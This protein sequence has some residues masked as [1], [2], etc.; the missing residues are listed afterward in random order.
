MQNR[1]WYKRLLAKK[2]SDF[3]EKMNERKPENMCKILAMAGIKPEKNKLA[4]DFAIEASE[5]MQAHADKDGFGFA[6]MTKDGALFGER[7]LHQ[8]DVFQNRYEPS[9][10]EKKALADFKGALVRPVAYNMFGAK[11]DYDNAAAIIMHARFATC[12]KA[13]YN[14]HP[15]VRDGVALIHNGV[16]NN[17]QELDIL[18]S[19]CDSESILNAYV[20][21]GVDEIPGN[22]DTVA[23]MLR[24]S[25]AVAT[26]GLT[27]TAS[28][29]YM[30]IFKNAATSLCVAKIKELDAWV[31]ATTAEIINKTAN[32]LKMTI[33]AS[34]WIMPGYLIRTN[35]L[36]GEI[37]LVEQFDTEYH[38]PSKGS[39][40]TGTGTGTGTNYTAGTG[41]SR[42]GRMDDV[43]SDDAPFTEADLDK[44]WERLEKSQEP[45]EK[46]PFYV[47]NG[48]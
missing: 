35:A 13:M 28:V 40:G 9:A 21:M 14:V 39:G 33:E 42:M 22:I 37:M 16:I 1:D 20:D 47:K 36:T 18:Q 30:D 23:G 25:Y 38:D 11:L 7:W 44:M 17:T 46:D 43:N 6:A 8:K 31:Y 29:P 5:H 4:W 32:A 12:E 41:R 19:T 10:I 24:G 26:L 45:N 3:K 27:D 2:R 15:F 34:F 48:S